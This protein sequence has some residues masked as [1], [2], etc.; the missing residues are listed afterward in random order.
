[1]ASGYC[2]RQ[3]SSRSSFLNP[4]SEQLITTQDSCPDLENDLNIEKRSSLKRNVAEICKLLLGSKPLFL[5]LFSK[6]SATIQWHCLL[7]EHHPH[8]KGVLLSCVSFD[9]LFIWALCTGCFL[10]SCYCSGCWGHSGEWG[11]QEHCSHILHLSEGTS[12]INNWAGKQEH[13]RVWVGA[14]VSLGHVS[15]TWGTRVGVRSSSKE[16]LPAEVTVELSCARRSSQVVQI[17]AQCQ[18]QETAHGE[19][20]VSYSKTQKLGC[21]QKGAK[22]RDEAKKW[23]CAGPL[24]TWQSSECYSNSRKSCRA[25]KWWDPNC[26]WRWHSSSGDF[27]GSGIGE[28]DPTVHLPQE[29][30][31]QPPCNQPLCQPWHL[32]RIAFCLHRCVVGP[33]CLY[34][35]NKGLAQSLPTPPPRPA[36]VKL[37]FT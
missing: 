7:Y 11:K 36:P 27:Y 16:N 15:V 6:Q 20:D 28:S 3:H 10:H 23:A 19:T 25:E 34:F 2:I 33:F 24:K 8:W 37:I 13:F 9:W 26:H 21:G 4:D 32:K 14:L 12:A 22:I 35:G 18:A 17:G 1:M 5:S 29:H 30:V 31:S